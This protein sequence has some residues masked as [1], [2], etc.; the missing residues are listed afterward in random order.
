MCNIRKLF[1]FVKYCFFFIFK[2]LKW[3]RLLIFCYKREFNFFFFSYKFYVI[4]NEICYRILIC[5][6]KGRKGNE[7]V[8]EEI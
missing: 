4:I 3:L 2:Y 8:K 6:I 7:V 5:C 1:Y